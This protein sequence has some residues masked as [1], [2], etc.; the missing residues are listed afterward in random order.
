MGPSVVAC[1]SSSIYRLE[2][3]NYVPSISL[4]AF[5]SIFLLIPSFISLFCIPELTAHWLWGS[6][7]V[8]RF[9]T[10]LFSNLSTTTRRQQI[11]TRWDDFN[12]IH[13]HQ[14]LNLFVKR[15]LNEI[16]DKFILRSKKKKD[17]FILQKSPFSLTNFSFK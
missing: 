12:K 9:K 5:F 15:S 7:Q 3:L 1:G 2:N 16:F 14:I 8:V 4:K 6:K 13:N 17:K 11:P 10:F